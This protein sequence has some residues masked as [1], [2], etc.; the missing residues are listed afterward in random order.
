MQ[1]NGG[2]KVAPLLFVF[3]IVKLRVVEIKQTTHTMFAVMMMIFISLVIPSTCM[4]GLFIRT[5]KVFD[6]CKG[7]GGR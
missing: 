2:L 5:L 3:V 1:P 4:T 7:I 6:D